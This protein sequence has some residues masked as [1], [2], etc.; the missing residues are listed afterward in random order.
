MAAILKKKRKQNPPRSFWFRNPDAKHVY[1]FTRPIG[2]SV[3]TAHVFLQNRNNLTTKRTNL[4]D[5]K[6]KLKFFDPNVFL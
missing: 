2:T 3:F 5:A 4:V 1:C 6:K